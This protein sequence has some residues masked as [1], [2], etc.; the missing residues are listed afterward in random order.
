MGVSDSAL[1]GKLQ[2]LTAILLGVVIALVLGE[3]GIRWHYTGRPLG[4]LFA[5][6]EDQKLI[7]D[8]DLGFRL[9][10]ARVEI[11]PLGFRRSK[12]GGEVHDDP[13]VLLVIGD[14]VSWDRNGFVDRLRT[15]IGSGVFPEGLKIVNAAVPAYTVHQERLFLERLAETLQPDFVLVQYCTND[16]HLFL[17]Q[18]QS[19]G[20]RVVTRAAKQAYLDEESGFLAWLTN[21]SDLVFEVRVAL[22]MLRE[23]ETS[24]FPWED[25]LY[26]EPAWTDEG[27]ALYET[28]LLAMKDAADELGAGFCVVGF[29]MLLQLDPGLR[30]MDA[31]YVDRP[32]TRLAE[33]C[34]AHGISCLNLLPPFLEAAES[35]LFRDGVHL[36]PAGHELAADELER[37]LSKHMR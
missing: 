36:T 29:P 21:K 37:F 4:S 3:V 9:N 35:D 28:E 25:D 7:H 30:A 33:L 32:H 11:D 13:F 26:Y 10:P 2:R 12:S 31:E 22:D 19:D 6:S 15:R 23:K 27:W 34:E 16:H 8:E 17:H 18:L 1:P 24:R 20:R 14:S 5:S